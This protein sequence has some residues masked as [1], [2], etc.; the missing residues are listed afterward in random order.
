[1][2]SG[3]LRSGL[4]YGM[5]SPATLAIIVA[6]TLA[7]VQ[8][9]VPKELAPLQGTWIIETVNGESLAAQG[10]H[11]EIAVTGNKYV[12]TINGAVDERGTIKI[13]TSKKPVWI[14]L[15]IE[16]GPADTSGMLQVGLIDVG[17][18]KATFHLAVPGATARPASFEPLPDQ[19]VIVVSKKK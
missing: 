14:D 10:A 17:A 11:G 18:D 15:M 3:P 16:Q 2:G 19:V 8:E 12:V 9:S 5:T 1:M 13:D 6:L 7:G 4:P